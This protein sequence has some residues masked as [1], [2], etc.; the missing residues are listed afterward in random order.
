MR[1]SAIIFFVLMPALSF[2]AQGG[3][4]DGEI[5]KAV[6]YQAINISILFFGV[7]FYSKDKIRSF[8]V[9]RRAEYLDASEKSAQARK[10]AELELVEI[11]TKIEAIE[12]KMASDLERAHIQAGQ[13]RLS[14]EEEARR[15]SQRI[16]E[17]SRLTVALEVDKAQ[18]ELRE[19]LLA[20]SLEAAR[21]VLK[22]DLSSADQQKLQK[23]F[24]NNIGV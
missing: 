16:K 14:L 17:E 5:P 7:A 24:I 1:L 8:F 12:S 3:Q 22:K 6:I 20:D 15:L 19:K 10:S 11:K 18:R 4:H 23:D 9:S 2:A 21:L 13:F